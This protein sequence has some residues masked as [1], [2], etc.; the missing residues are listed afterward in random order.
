[1][2]FMKILHFFF[3]RS[4]LTETSCVYNEIPQN[5]IQCATRRQHAVR[6]RRQSQPGHY[7]SDVEYGQE[8]R[9]VAVGRTAEFDKHAERNR[10][11]Y[12]EQEK[13]PNRPNGFGH[14]MFDIHRMLGTAVVQIRIRPD[15]G[16]KS[17]RARQSKSW[18]KFAYSFIRTESHVLL[19]KGKRLGVMPSTPT[20]QWL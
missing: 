13:N 6:V 15:F 9:Q 14:H 16:S 2:I 5:R 20:P 10:F 8:H 4:P 19:E 1:M 12:A 11:T 18:S 17:N 7:K 3:L